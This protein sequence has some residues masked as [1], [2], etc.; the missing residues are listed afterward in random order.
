MDK[1]NRMPNLLTANYCRKLILPILCIL[2]NSSLANTQSPP[3]EPGVSQALAQWRAAR[4]SDVR[5][6]LNLTLEKMSPVLKGTIEI[7]LS[8]ASASAD[9]S[10]PIILD[11]RKIKGHEDK[12]TIS[13]VTI[14][15]KL[16]KSIFSRLVIGPGLQRPPGR[17]TTL[18]TESVTPKPSPSP[19]EK[20]LIY[21]ERDD[22][23]IFEEGVVAGENVIKL[24]FTSPILT[25]GSAITRYVD[26]EDGAEYIYSLFVPSDASTAF[27]VF[28][29][30]DLKARFTLDIKV[31]KEWMAVTNSTQARWT[32]YECVVGQFCADGY[33][34]EETKPISTYV[35]AFAVGPFEEFTSGTPILDPENSN[36]PPRNIKP[37]LKDIYKTWSR[38]DITTGSSNLFLPHIY[39]RKSQAAKF[40]PHAAEVFRLN[41]E[42]IKYLETYFDYKFLSKIRSGAD[43]GVS[44]FGDGACGGDFFA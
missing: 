20:T 36:N 25:S 18:P 26:K 28:D 24:D 21:V 39:V 37:E 33:G 3:I 17:I 2:L 34:F 8:V 7:R 16:V 40:K 14:N 6:K 27:P 29:Q 19:D 12:S 32:R 9:A 5:Y 4:Y 10:T 31:D 38:S 42:G 1:I 23:L 15:G 35:F 43:T 44:V 13:N 11:W 22:H 41:R 30:P